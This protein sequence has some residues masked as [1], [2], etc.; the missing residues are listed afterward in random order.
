AGAHCDGQVLV[1]HDLLGLFDRFT[2]KFAK[3][4]ANLQSQ[5]MQAFRDYVADVTSHRFPSAEHCYPIREEELRALLESLEEQTV[6]PTARLKS[7]PPAFGVASRR[8]METL[9]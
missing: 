4:Y 7:C 6:P 3:Q 2:P 8:I 9:W 5:M 1:T